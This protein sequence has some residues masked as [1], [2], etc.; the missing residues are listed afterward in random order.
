[1]RATLL[2]VPYATLTPEEQAFLSTAHL[3]V[4]GGEDSDDEDITIE[5][6]FNGL[7]KIV[8]I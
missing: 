2:Q 8:V 5:G 6:M 7:T 4:D 3:D 1:M